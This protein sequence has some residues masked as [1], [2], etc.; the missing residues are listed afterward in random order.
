MEKQVVNSLEAWKGTTNEALLLLDSLSECEE[1]RIKVR[2]CNL[3]QFDEPEEAAQYQGYILDKITQRYQ[4]IKE[5]D[6]YRKDNPAPVDEERVMSIMEGILESGGVEFL[7][8]IKAGHD[9]SI[10]FE[11]SDYQ[12][13]VDF[14]QSI[15]KLTK[16]PV[17]SQRAK[18]IV[19]EIRSEFASVIA[20]YSGV[21]ETLK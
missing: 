10:D 11:K 13:L 6:E 18:K 7:D 16:I 2:K 3:N 8:Q 15:D 5:R 4:A 14:I 20:Q 1:L 19:L 17:V 12:K 21:I 9:V